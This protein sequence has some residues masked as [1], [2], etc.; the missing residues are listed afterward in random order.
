MRR[1]PDRFLELC[2]AFY[3]LPIAISMKPTVAATTT[4]RR[5]HNPSCH[6]KAIAPSNP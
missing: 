6:Y 3:H 2:F 5:L 4:F 1:S